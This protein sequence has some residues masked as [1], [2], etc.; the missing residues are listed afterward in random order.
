V[1]A[2]DVQAHDLVIDDRF[3]YFS[4]DDSIS[5]VPKTGGEVEKLDTH[6]SKYMAILGTDL[7]FSTDGAI[8]HRTTAC[9]ATSDVFSAQLV[10]PAALSVDAKWVYAVDWHTSAVWKIS[11]ANGAA[12]KLH[13]Y[14]KPMRLLAWN[15]LVLVSEWTYGINLLGADGTELA[16]YGGQRNDF[17]A[18][19][20]DA[21][22]SP[23]WSEVR[24]ASLVEHQYADIASTTTANGIAVDG[25]RV[26][27]A[28]GSGIWRASQPPTPANA[29]LLEP[30]TGALLVAVDDVC[31][32][33][34]TND[35]VVRTPK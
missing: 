26:Y 2:S 7:F 32:Y 27:W 13:A 31:V 23:D 18:A 3:V 5:R 22:F 21:L 29:T 8:R 10:T 35:R 24:Y 34:A 16:T 20:K 30:A 6:G 11:R 9:D 17:M 1:L 28:D 4:T 25:A 19:T 33:Y 14:D 15:D 12:T